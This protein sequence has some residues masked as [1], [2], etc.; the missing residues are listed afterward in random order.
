MVG[1]FGRATKKINEAADSVEIKINKFYQQVDRMNEISSE[2]NESATSMA[3]IVSS[4]N[5]LVVNVA[6]GAEEASV[7]TQT[8]SA[9]AK[10]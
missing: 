4:A 1:A 9:A 3:T 8:V 10:N 5:E 2:L 6:S 7:N